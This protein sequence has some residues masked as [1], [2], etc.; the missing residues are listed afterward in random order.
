MS[1]IQDLFFEKSSSLFKLYECGSVMVSL[2]V[3]SMYL[4]L[5]QETGRGG[6]N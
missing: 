4:G 2:M 1:D 6:P 3:Q 5:S